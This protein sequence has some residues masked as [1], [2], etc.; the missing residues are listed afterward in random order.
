M[1]LRRDSQG[2]YSY[3]FV[4]DTDQVNQAKEEVLQAEQDLFN[5]DKDRNNEVIE[6]MLN[7][8]EEYTQKII[9]LQSDQTKSAQEKQ[10]LS[11]LYFKEYNDN[12]TALAKE[13]SVTRINLHDDVFNNLNM[14]YDKNLYNFINMSEQEQDEFMNNLLPN[15]NSTAAE[16]SETVNGE[17]G[18]LPLTQDS[19][20][21]LK[22]L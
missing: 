20:Q 12:I 3:Q 1:R 13:T 8:Y 7:T 17:G 5:F 2:N 21:E 14:L 6:E 4:Q 15:W 16:M 10:Q 22:D 9:S 19:V 11:E 18:L